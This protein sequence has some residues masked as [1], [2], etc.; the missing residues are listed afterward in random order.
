M[1]K[2]NKTEM[3]LS[4]HVKRILSYEMSFGKVMMPYIKAVS[5][6]MKAD[7]MSPVNSA[8]GVALKGIKKGKMEKHDLFCLMVAASLI[9][10]RSE[11][12]P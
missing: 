5:R 3:E 2:G 6:Q 4:A 11:E 1:K 9:E 7:T 12:L 8:I 10:S